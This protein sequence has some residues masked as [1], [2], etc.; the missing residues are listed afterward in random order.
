MAHFTATN[1]VDQTGPFNAFTGST[2]PDTLIVDADA[3]LIAEQSNFSGA[4]LTGSWTVTI[5]GAVEG[6]GPSGHGLSVTGSTSDASTIKVGSSADVFGTFIGMSINEKTT[7]DNKGV[8]SGGDL[9]AA[10]LVQISG[11]L[12]IKNSG[13]I[14][15]YSNGVSCGGAGVMTIVNRG[16]ISS[17]GPNS[18]SI[19]G[20]F[21]NAAH[22]TNSGTL[23]GTIQ[24]ANIDDT[25]TDFMK[26]GKHVKNGSV[27]GVIDLGGGTNH[28]T[29]G[30]NTETVRDHG[31]TDTVKLG[32][33][34]DTYLAVPS[35]DSPGN[36]ALNG[37]KGIDTY[38]AS[39]TP[40]TVD[41]NFDTIS[42]GILFDPQTALGTD[43]GGDHL[44]GFEN[45]IG[46][47]GS[48]T[49]FGSSGANH[50]DGGNGADHLYGLGGRDVLTG[51]G[52]GDTFHFLKLTDSGLTA[53]TRDLI[54]DFSQSDG[55]KIDLSVIDANGS[56]V[57]DPDFDFVGFAQFSHTKGE[58]RESFSSG[59]T[60]VSGDVNG[61]GK[62][63]FSIALTGHIVL[64]SGDF[65]L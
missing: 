13:L 27:N 11:D 12:T 52:D 23:V 25:F 44:T 45:A 37:G 6:L 46:G 31:G 4:N 34:N 57:G 22:I 24:L 9:S 2:G 40:N 43:V 15:G 36:G 53:S 65:N 56:A 62:A 18:N 48:D 42:H 63:D 32:G 20:S 61:D 51:G 49:I 16:T 59:N 55:D 1:S 39:G 30:A 41:I 58:L 7:L 54:T 21:N 33:G 29:G 38:D 47:D 64:T 19:Q 26:V 50:L 14:Q 28:F 35:V 5:N 60:I 17:T 10:G 8:I 3:F